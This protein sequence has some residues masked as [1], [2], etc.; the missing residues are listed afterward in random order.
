MGLR[1]T[2]ESGSVNGEHV[3][4]PHC[5]FLASID[6]KKHARVL[7]EIARVWPHLKPHIRGAIFTLLDCALPSNVVGRVEQ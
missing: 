2:P 7:A 4:C 5:R 6:A 3:K 1:K